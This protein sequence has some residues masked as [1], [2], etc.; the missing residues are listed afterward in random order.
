MEA[1]ASSRLVMQMVLQR[2]LFLIA[3]VWV[4]EAQDAYSETMRL[5]TQTSEDFT[6]PPNKSLQPTATARTV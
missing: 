4:G 2:K 1:V 3:W 6:M 5:F